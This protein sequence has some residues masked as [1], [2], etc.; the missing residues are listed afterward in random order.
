MPPHHNDDFPPL[1]IVP[2][3][4]HLVTDDPAWTYT[5]ACAG[6][7]GIALLRVWRTAG[8]GHLA[9]VTENGI[10]VSITNA[11]E[12][13]SAA[14]ADRYPGPLVILEHYRAGDGAPHD[15][16]DQVLVVPGRAPRWRPVWPTGPANPNFAINRTWMSELGSVLLAARAH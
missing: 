12:E 2:D 10:A 7:G 9:I 11:A 8:D 13:I 14:L 5:S 1:P 15:R 6:G 16:L 4:H 3:P